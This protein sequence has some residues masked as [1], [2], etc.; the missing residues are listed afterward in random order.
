MPT[1]DVDEE[2]YGNDG[3]ERHEAQDASAGD[4]RAIADADQAGQLDISGWGENSENT[5]RTPEPPT[6]AARMAHNAT[7][8]PFRDWCPILCCESRTKC[9]A[10]TSCGEQDGG[11]SAKIPDRLHVHSN[12]GSEQ[13]SAMYHICGNAQ[14]S[15]GSASCAPGK[16]VM[17][18]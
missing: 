13:N 12:S 7:H 3:A 18:T 8:V 4:R 6:D 10:Q 9:S 16:E 5:L 14:W 15:G 17:R 11:Y 1:N 2:V